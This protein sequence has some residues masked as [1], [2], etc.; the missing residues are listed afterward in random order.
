MKESY[1]K[2]PPRSGTKNFMSFPMTTDVTDL[3]KTLV[4]VAEVSMRF[5]CMARKAPS[6]KPAPILVA[7]AE[8]GAAPAPAIAPASGAD[9]GGGGGRA[10]TPFL[11]EDQPVGKCPECLK[12][13]TGNFSDCCGKELR[14]A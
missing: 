3:A 10:A 1:N 11:M 9:E 12:A 7:P 8:G 4:Q 13:C 6:F 2:A 14:K 5:S